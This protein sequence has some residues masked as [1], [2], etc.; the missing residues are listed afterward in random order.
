YELVRRW[1][2]T[3]EAIEALAADRRRENL[4][5]R[6]LINYSRDEHFR[7]YLRIEQKF[8]DA[9]DGPPFTPSPETDRHPAAAGSRYY[10]WSSSEELRDRLLMHDDCEM[11]AE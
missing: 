11:Q 1:K 10:V 3:E 5:V 2:L 9:E 7:Q 8:D 6:R 4:G